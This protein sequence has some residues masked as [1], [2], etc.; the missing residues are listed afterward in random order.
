MD[1]LCFPL[2][3]RVISSRSVSGPVVP[4]AQPRSMSMF[5]SEP[6]HEN[7]F[8]FGGQTGKSDSSLSNSFGYLAAGAVG[9]ALGAGACY[10]L[11]K[12]KDDEQKKKSH[13]SKD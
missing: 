11:A 13:V 1:R 12:N 6:E 10:L 4:R 8:S 3:R 5:E 9:A 7:A 2:H